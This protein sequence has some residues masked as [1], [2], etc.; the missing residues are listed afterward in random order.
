MH[1]YWFDSVG[2]IGW[3]TILIAS[4]PRRVRIPKWNKD[5]PLVLLPMTEER[6]IFLD[7]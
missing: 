1:I 2:T 4:E 6:T 7:S 5:N 3:M